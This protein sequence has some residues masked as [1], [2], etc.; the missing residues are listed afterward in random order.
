MPWLPDSEFAQ[1]DAESRAWYESLPES[2]QWSQSAV[3][4]RKETSQLGA[5]CG[6]HW[7]YNQNMCDL[8]RIGAPA[9]YKLRNAFTFPPE[10]SAYVAWLQDEL[11]IH[12]RRIG[13]IAAEALR[14]GPHALADSWATTVVYD[15]SRVM[16]FYLTQILDPT[17]ERNK[18]LMEETIP[19]IRSN[20]KA[21]K[22]MQ[23]MYAVAELLANAAEKMLEKIGIVPDAALVGQS[24]IPDEPYPANENDEN[25]R[26][27]PGTPVQSAPDYVLNPLS[28]YRMA[29]KGI[30][31]KH[32]PEKQRNAIST[33]STSPRRGSLQRRAT[34]QHIPFEG[35]SM[36]PMPLAA[37]SYG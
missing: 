13:I 14:H 2:L 31:E 16:L 19:L 15:C 21:L 22:K 30:S 3:Y 1:L 26:S 20:V 5:L 4:I 32:A 34:L 37:N 35:N 8:F 36:A 7:I 29:R 28:I 27:Q 6:L 23:S 11:F 9:L 10:Q 33:A 25:E 17:T 18:A 12:A 24:I